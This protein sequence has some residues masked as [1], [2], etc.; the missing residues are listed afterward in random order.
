MA[1]RNSVKIQISAEGAAKTLK[2][3]AKINK[4]LNT[5]KGV[6]GGIGGSLELP[7]GEKAR[8]SIKH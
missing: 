1:D 7:D 3:L 2:E 8:K 6:K 5:L 4:Q